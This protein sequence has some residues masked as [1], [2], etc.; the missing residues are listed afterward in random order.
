MS[1]QALSKKDG[2]AK[3]S[4]NKSSRKRKPEKP[5]DV[6]TNCWVENIRNKK[7]QS[8]RKPNSPRSSVRTTLYCKNRKYPC[9]IKFSLIVLTSPALQISSVTFW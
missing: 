5:K 4:N 1:P 2:F 7:I 8:F 3:M 6:L 9:T